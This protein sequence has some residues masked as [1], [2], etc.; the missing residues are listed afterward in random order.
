MK[1]PALPCCTRGHALVPIRDGT[2]CKS[3]AV[4]SHPN[5]LLRFGVFRS[6]IRIQ[7]HC[8]H[9]RTQVFPAAISPANLWYRFAYRNPHLNEVNNS[10]FQKINFDMVA[11]IKPFQDLW[12]SKDTKNKWHSDEHHRRKKIKTTIQTNKTKRTKQEICRTS[13]CWKPV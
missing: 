10:H 3:S 8:F 1:Q 11:I 5:F 7:A 13:I 12:Y 4:F 9:W 6:R 2:K